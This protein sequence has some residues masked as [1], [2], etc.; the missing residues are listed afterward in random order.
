[1]ARTKIVGGGSKKRYRSRSTSAS[2][3]DSFSSGSYSGKIYVITRI[4]YL[5]SLNKH[6]QVR[7]TS[8]DT[9]LISQEA[10]QKKTMSVPEKTY[11]K[12]PKVLVISVCGGL[13]R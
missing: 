3:Q 1:M 6:S 4:I 12:T 5:T 13:H 10:A 9:I 7:Y 2:S 8:F 11:K